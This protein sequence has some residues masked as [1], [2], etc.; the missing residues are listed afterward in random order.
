MFIKRRL[1]PLHFLRK[2]IP[3]RAAVAIIRFIHSSTVTC[4]STMTSRSCMA[5]VGSLGVKVKVICN[6]NYMACDYI[7]L[8]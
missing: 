7:N 5:D 2:W 1:N 6:Q 3:S 8:R 4:F